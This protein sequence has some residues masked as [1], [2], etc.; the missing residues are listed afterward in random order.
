MAPQG[1]GI[2]VQIEW[3]IWPRMGRHVRLTMPE[4]IV[5]RFSTKGGNP[6]L[7]GFAQRR[8]FDSE[9]VAHR[10]R[11]DFRPDPSEP[12]QEPRA[13]QDISPQPAEVRLSNSLESAMAVS[14]DESST[15]RSDGPFSPSSTDY[16]HDAMPADAEGYGRTGV[17]TNAYCDGVQE[18]EHVLSLLRQF[19]VHFVAAHERILETT[20][21]PS[22]VGPD[23]DSGGQ[24]VAGSQAS[25]FEM[26]APSH[27]AETP[28]SKWRAL[29]R[30]F[31]LFLL[32]WC[33][34]ELTIVAT[35]P[36][37][38]PVDDE[39]RQRAFISGLARIVR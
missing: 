7:H 9:P 15:L 31:N 24:A 8:Q 34:V 2:G 25:E 17:T 4:W 38:M 12:T 16:G 18:H 39:D 30:P 1:V 19:L 32:A 23:G 21:Y 11:V 5:A 26:H 28:K 27:Q 35:I 10:E 20:A 6:A 29:L 13:L 3:S 36:F 33:A 37:K 14:R 22:A